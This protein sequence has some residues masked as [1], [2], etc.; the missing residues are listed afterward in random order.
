MRYLKVP[1]IC[2]TFK[3]RLRFIHFLFNVFFIFSYL[4][5]FSYF[6]FFLLIMCWCIL[7]I[8]RYFFFF[9]LSLFHSQLSPAVEV[10]PKRFFFE[11]RGLV[12]VLAVVVRR[13]AG[14]REVHPREEQQLLGGR[15]FEDEGEIGRH[16]LVRSL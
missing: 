13:H 12:P 3:Y 9:P 11:R 8:L 2:G 7:T 15:C 6:F 14:H 5:F 16:D 10:S 4:A 1:R